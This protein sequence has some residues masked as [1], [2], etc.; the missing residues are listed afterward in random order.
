MSL[1]IVWFS[2]ITHRRLMGICG[3][4]EKIAEKEKDYYDLCRRIENEKSFFQKRFLIFVRLKN[5]SPERERGGRPGS[6][7]A[8]SRTIFIQSPLLRG[9]VKHKNQP[10]LKIRKVILHSPPNIIHDVRTLPIPLRHDHHS[11]DSGHFRPAESGRY[12]HDSILYG[13]HLGCR[14]SCDI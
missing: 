2:T 11:T 12:F 4:K 5:P 1:N 7:R 14:A 6:P 13:R 9:V 3:R 10:I 8:G